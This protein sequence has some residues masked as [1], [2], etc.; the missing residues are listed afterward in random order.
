MSDTNSYG[1][2]GEL[3]KSLIALKDKFL[4]FS[5]NIKFYLKQL[6]DYLDLEYKMY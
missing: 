1:E 3:Q 5:V 6:R 2:L 4:V